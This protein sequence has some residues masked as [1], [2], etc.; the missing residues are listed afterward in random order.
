MQFRNL[1]II[2]MLTAGI[3]VGVISILLSYSLERLMYTL[4]VVLFV[5]YVFGSLVQNVANHIFERAD[6]D[7]REKEMALLEEE[8]QELEQTVPE[9][10]EEMA[11]SSEMTEE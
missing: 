7:E 9:V 10:S 8:E 4:F 2:M 11:E 5:F 3:I 6:Q 1:N